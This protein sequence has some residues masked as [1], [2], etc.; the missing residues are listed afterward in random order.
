[1]FEKER[2]IRCALAEDVG[3]GD[4]TT[5]SL[6]EP[7]RIGKAAIIAKEDLVLA[8]LEL[9]QS[10][11][12]TLDPK[13]AFETR[14]KD[15]DAV[16]RGGR[17]ITVKGN[18]RSLLRGERCALNF[19]QRLSGIA[20]LTRRFV[21][22]IEGTG[23][24]LV[25]TRKTTP[26]WRW[27]EK[28]AVRMGGG[29]NHRFGLFDGVLIK[30]NHVVA[31]GGI[32]EAMERIRQNLPTHMVRIEVEVSDLRGVEEAI[33]SG[34]DIIMLD[35]M[36]LADISEAV[37]LIAGRCLIEVSGGINLDNIAALAET[38]VDLI[39]VG[40]LTHSASAVDISMKLLR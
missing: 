26:G 10:V 33:N 7:D 12:T 15:G 4:I 13:M 31:C 38:G 22:R 9:A 6:I 28:Y 27:W 17:I 16:E 20:T 25:D 35:N 34:A 30:D 32:K 2:L 21:E 40:A 18:L 14:Y 3:S 36:D 8:G 29:R 39:S 5:D 23:V 11:F 37:N 24:R 19:L 1:M